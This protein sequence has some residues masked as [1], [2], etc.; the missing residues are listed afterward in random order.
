Q[1]FLFV[2]STLTSI[3]VYSLDN[4]IVA[5]IIPNSLSS[6][7]SQL[8]RFMIGSMVMVLPFSKLYTIYDSKWVYITSIV[9]FLATSALCGAAPTIKVEIIRRIFTSAGG[10]GMYFSLLALLSTYTTPR[11]QPQYLS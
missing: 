6:A 1:W 5:N 10:N 2:F 8:A 4:T 9:V 11:E 7:Y 3:F